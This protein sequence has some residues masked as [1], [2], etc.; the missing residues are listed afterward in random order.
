MTPEATA[1]LNEA[2]DII[3]QN[4]L[5]REQVN[6]HEVRHEVSDLVKE[7]EIPADT[8]VAI[9]IALASSFNVRDDSY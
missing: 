2:L 3:Q 9:K 1:Y 4:A 7:A 6:W 5:K 8:Y